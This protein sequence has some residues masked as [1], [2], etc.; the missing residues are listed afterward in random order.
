MG[1]ASIRPLNLSELRAR[2]DVSLAQMSKSMGTGRGNVH[3]IENA[4]NPQLATVER[5][6]ATLGMALVAV[7]VN[8]QDEVAR[9]VEKGGIVGATHSV[10]MLEE[11]LGN[12]GS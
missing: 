4:S 11:L 9:L 12:N 7:P 3:R 1:Q 8:M 10:G 6:L 5:Y 2:A